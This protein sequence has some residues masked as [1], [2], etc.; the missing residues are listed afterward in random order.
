MSVAGFSTVLMTFFGVNY[1][2]SGLHSY[3]T[4][5]GLP[6]GILLGSMACIVILI[7]L[8]SRRYYKDKKRSKI[9]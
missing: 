7:F 3:G 4:S 1:Y 5:E 2:L 9:S 8:A 6:S